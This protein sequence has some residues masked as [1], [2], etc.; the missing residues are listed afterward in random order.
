MTTNPN[1]YIPTTLKP[2]SRIDYSKLI[3]GETR[4]KMIVL[5]DRIDTAICSLSHDMPLLTKKLEENSLGNLVLTYEWPASSEY[6]FDVT[7]FIRTVHSPFSATILGV[8]MGSNNS[9]LILTLK[10]PYIQV[11]GEEAI[12]T[13]CLRR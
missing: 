4:S 10:D 12:T 13:V 8:L 5:V 7:Q 11:T 2:I 6:F 1:Y 9:K 3:N